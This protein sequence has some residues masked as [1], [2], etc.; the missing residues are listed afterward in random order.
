MELD[1]EKS[2]AIASAEGLRTKGDSAPTTGKSEGD[3][4]GSTTTLQ[5]AL[6]TNGQSSGGDISMSPVFNQVPQ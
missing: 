4:N 5:T 6:A 2:G 1:P 3:I